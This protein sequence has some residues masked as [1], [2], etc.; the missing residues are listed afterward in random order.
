MTLVDANVLLRF[1]TKQPPAQAEAAREVLERGQ[2]GEFNLVVEPL[3]LAEV[4]YVLA[5]VYGYPVERIRTEL[6]DLIHTDAVW[7]ETTLLE[8]AVTDA[9]MKLS[10][11]LDSPDTY[12]PARAR[13]SGGQVASFDKGFGTLEVDWLEV[14]RLEPGRDG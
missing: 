12:P 4:V 8:R 7:L 11:E 5:G 3:T 10:S 9:L 2:R 1:L 14:D 6:L 13:L